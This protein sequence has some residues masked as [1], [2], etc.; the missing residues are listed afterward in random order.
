MMLS[1][2]ALFFASAFAAPAPVL[3]KVQLSNDFTGKNADVDIAVNSGPHTFGQLFSGTFGAQVLATS[4]QAVS[5]GAGG[6]KVQCD[7]I[8]RGTPAIHAYLNSWN[9][10][11]DLDGNPNKATPTDVT[12]FTIEC[13]LY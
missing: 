7:I 4:I 9:T 2:A 5:P 3:F 13:Q 8:N 12:G 6:N 10:F 1:S 11:V